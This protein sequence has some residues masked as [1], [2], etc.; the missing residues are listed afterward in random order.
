VTLVLYGTDIMTIGGYWLAF[1]GNI[2]TAH[3]QKLLF[4]GFRSK[5]W[6]CR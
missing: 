6:H 2:F 3:A 4:S 1:F 5:F